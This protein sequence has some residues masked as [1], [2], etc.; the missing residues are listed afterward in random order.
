[1]VLTTHSL[2]PEIL[3]GALAGGEGEENEAECWNVA[4]ISQ[5][6][7]HYIGVPVVTQQKRIRLVST[8]MRIPSLTS[9]SGL[10]IWHCCG[11][12]CMLQTWLGSCVAVAVVWAGSCSSDST[13][14]LGTSICR[15]CG[16]KK[17]K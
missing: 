12:W 16:P 14:S 7:S 6:R 4:K 3:I 17:K 5:F 2:R 10:R 13:P 8:R 1:M 11:L 15:G 9:L